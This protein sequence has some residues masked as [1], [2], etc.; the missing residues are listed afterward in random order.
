MNEK[1]NSTLKSQKEHET[2]DFQCGN[3][4]QNNRTQKLVAADR[5]VKAIQAQRV[6]CETKKKYKICFSA[7]CEHT[8]R[9]SE[10]EFQSEIRK[11]LKI[12]D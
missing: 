5:S 9:G 4:T 7:D 8:E 11:I 6:M 2:N 1:S 12:E 10:R 3:V